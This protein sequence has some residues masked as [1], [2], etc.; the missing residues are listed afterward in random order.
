MRLELAVESEKGKGQARGKRGHLI[1]RF[2]RKGG[3]SDGAAW[4]SKTKHEWES[5]GRGEGEGGRVEL[6]IGGSRIIIRKAVHDDGEQCP[7]EED[8]VGE[9]AN[10]P[11]PERSV[12]DVVAATNEEG[13]DGNGVGDVEEDYAG[14]D[15]TVRG[16]GDVSTS[17]FVVEVWRKEIARF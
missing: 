1:V 12:A 5:N 8:I 9:C 6:T 4:F 11:E 10:G 15:H 2:P 13:D 17:C 16:V 14:C 7:S 3:E